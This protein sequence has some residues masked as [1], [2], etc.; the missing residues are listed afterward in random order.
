M[1]RTIAIAAAAVA[2]AVIAITPAAASPQFLPGLTGTKF[3]GKSGKFLFQQGPK[4]AVFTCPE[5][6]ISEGKGKIAK[7]G[8]PFEELFIMD[9]G[10]CVFFGRGMST[11]GDAPGTVLI[12]VEGKLCYINKATEEIGL[13]F[14]FLPVHMEWAGIPLE[15]QGSF[16]A[17]IEPFNFKA[18]KFTLHIEQ[19]E[20]TQSITKCEGEA[21]REVLT[22]IGTKMVKTGFE[23]KEPTI[24]FGEEQTLME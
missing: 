11:E 9:V 4:G 6:V 3:T 16:V 13:I 5:M 18:K 22:T 1:Q 14:E 2:L 21:A 7:K 12:H 8:E 10:P 23:L 24:T 19:K 17:R 15:M 20:G